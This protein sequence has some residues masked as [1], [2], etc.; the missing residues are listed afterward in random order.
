MQEKRFKLD[1]SEYTIEV[2]VRK[3]GQK[4]LVKEIIDYPIRNNLSVWLRMAGMFRTGEDVAEAVCLAKQIRDE[5]SNELILDEREAG[6]LRLVIDRLLGMAA[7]GN[8]GNNPFGGELHEEV[9]CRVVN[10]EEI[11]A[12]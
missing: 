2:D 10:M 4:E 6:I 11:K 12:E 9:I 8:M 7:D 3:D 1:V 5:E